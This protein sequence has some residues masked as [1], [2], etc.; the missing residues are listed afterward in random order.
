MWLCQAES[1]NFIDP[2]LEKLSLSI[3]IKLGLKNTDLG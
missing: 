3:Y 1:Q 2:V